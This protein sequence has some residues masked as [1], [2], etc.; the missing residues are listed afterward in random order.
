MITRQMLIRNLSLSF[1]KSESHKMAPNLLILHGGQTNTFLFMR[2]V[3]LIFRIASVCPLRKRCA[4]LC[5]ASR[6]TNSLRLPHLLVV[7]AG[8]S[9]S[10]PRRSRRPLDLQRC[11]PAPARASRTRSPGPLQ[12]RS[13]GALSR[14]ARPQP[15]AVPSW[16]AR[17][18]TRRRRTT[19]I[20]HR[21]ASTSL[22]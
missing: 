13:A 14:K 19:R 2:D 1:Q 3:F 8:T 22:R 4:K 6:D 12:A 21:R 11:A 18:R 17:P 20:R 5:F 16:R 10:V 9:P 15:G 7:S